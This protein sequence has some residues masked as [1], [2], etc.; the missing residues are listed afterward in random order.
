[1][2]LRLISGVGFLALIGVAFA[3]SRT[4][5]QVPWR[6]V[7]FMLV[8]QIVL[9]VV[10]IANP[11]LP[12]LLWQ[13]HASVANLWEVASTGASGLLGFSKMHPDEISG[14]DARFL[15]TSPAFKTLPRLLVFSGL[16]G[17]LYYVGVTPRLI[18]IIGKRIRRS[19][20]TDAECL[21]AAGST[22]LGPEVLLL[23]HKHVGRMS[24]SALTT[25]LSVGMTA[26]GSNF[27]AYQL[28]EMRPAVI[29]AYVAASLISLPGAIAISKILS[30]PD[31]DTKPLPLSNEVRAESGLLDELFATVRVAG[32]MILFAVGFIIIVAGMFQL[33]NEI[34]SSLGNRFNHV[35]DS[36]ISWSLSSCLG[37]L[38][39]PITVLIGV[40]I[41]D[42]P[43][44]SS[45]LGTRA[46]DGEI[47]ALRELLVAVD[48]KRILNP[49]SIALSIWSI[50]GFASTI[51]A[52]LW[53]GASAALVEKR[54]RLLGIGLRAWLGAMIA[55]LI[56]ACLGGALLRP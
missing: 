44:V 1:M 18:Q 41:E 30:P 31:A 53:I 33:F 17:L 22:I 28:L 12:Q 45:V 40:P 11:R 5:R 13:L 2:S 27:A 8:L 52:T 32:R 47:A 9:V 21:C 38:L 15:L 24:D 7:G 51:G 50:S 6:L 55:L 29:N 36:Q 16:A 48:E 25:V 10:F 26:F 4:R 46:F 19:R 49:R 42:V 43:T 34:L 3:L 23:A 14:S 56:S 54:R 37:Y 35:F 20:M 39:H